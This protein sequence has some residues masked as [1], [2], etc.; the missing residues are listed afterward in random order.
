MKI[1]GIHISSGILK[2]LRP[3][4]GFYVFLV[5]LAIASG[6]WLLNSLTHEYSVTVDIPVKYDGYNEDF[7]ISNS[8]PQELHFTVRGEGFTLLS[9]TQSGS[10]DTLVIDVTRFMNEPVESGDLYSAA[11][12]VK[13]L[14]Q[15]ITSAAGNRLSFEDVDLDSIHVTLE[16]KVTRSIAVEKP[17]GIVPASQYA[18]RS[19]PVLSPDSVLISGPKSVLDTIRSIK[20]EVP[21]IKNADQ[22]QAF[23]ISLNIP[24]HQVKVEP[25]KV[26]LS[27]EVEPLTEGEFLITIEPQF[28]PDSLEVSLYP[29]TVNIRFAAGLSYFDNVNS[30]DFKAYVDCSAITDNNR[31]KLMV[32]PETSK[33]IKIVTHTPEQVEFLVRKR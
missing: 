16:R 17:F 27:F 10:Y 22:S 5:C 9:K 8:P 1:L 23:D 11:F 7:I 32:H 19:E 12:S 18:F 26:H 21:E 3:R 30:E 25:E 14:K 33:N 24:H 28:V 4:R 31:N 6:F 20:A 2:A 13:Q 15:N 29:S